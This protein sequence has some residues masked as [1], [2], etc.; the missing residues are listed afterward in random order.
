M[1]F[2]K[3]LPVHAII[4]ILSRLHYTMDFVLKVVIYGQSDTFKANLEIPKN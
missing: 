4:L 2:S 3:R 1:I